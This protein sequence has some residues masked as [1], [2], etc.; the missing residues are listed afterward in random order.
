MTFPDPLPP[1]LVAD[2]WGARWSFDGV[3]L[4][5]S[6]GGKAASIALEPDV[7]ARV[8]A[9][10]AAA[11]AVHEEE[12]GTLW[13]EHSVP[14]G[15]A[16][17][18]RIRWRENTTHSPWGDRLYGLLKNLPLNGYE[19]SF[20]LQPGHLLSDRFLLGLRTAALAVEDI[21][22]IARAMNAPDGFRLRMLELLAESTFLHFGYEAS[23]SQETLKIYLEFPL[24]QEGAP[25]SGQ[26]LYLGFKWAAQDPRQQAV[27]TYSQPITW[28]ADTLEKEIASACGDGH[29][30]ACDAVAQIVRLALKRAAAGALPLVQVADNETPRQSFD[31]NL[32]AASLDLAEVRPL[33]QALHRHFSIGDTDMEA[34]AQRFDSDLVGHLSCGTDRHGQPFVTVY[35]AARQA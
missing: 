19:R 6:D 18:A 8:A 1:E 7:M 14:A 16:C 20:K 5:F 35:H 28:S 33:L 11:V 4:V 34:L 21:D 27:S 9:Q 29:P 30:L 3:T 26:P 25:K 15:A 31:I 23:P 22:A 10:L 12:H 17:D 24:M 2:R 13:S 32:Y